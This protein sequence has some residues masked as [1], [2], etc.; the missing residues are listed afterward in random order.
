MRKILVVDDE[1]SIREMLTIYLQREGYAVT[2]ASD[3]AIALACCE[4][5]FYDIVIADIKM[6]K[7]DGIELLHKVRTLSPDTIFI[8]ITAFGSYETAKESMQEDAYDYITKPFDVEDIKKK[9]EAALAKRQQHTQP[10]GIDVSAQTAADAGCFAMIGKSM[11]MQ[12]IF[13]L[14][15]RAASAK[16][17]V[18]ITGESGTGKELVA[19]AI[20]R[21]SAQAAHP[22]IIINCG[23][24]PETLLESELFGYRKGAFTGAVKDKKGLLE[25]AHAGTLFLDEIGE[26]PLS[27][28]VKL[29]RMVQEKTFT[30]VG[31]TEEIKVDVRIISATNKDLAK[32]VMEGSFREDLYYRLNVINIA[33]PALRERKEDIPLLANFFLKK[34]AQETDKE[35]TE[36]SSFAMDCLMNYHFPGNIRE[37]ENIIE[38]GVALAKTSIMLPDSLDI[39]LHKTEE[40]QKGP[41]REITLP[42]EGMLLDAVLATYERAY[43]EEALRVSRGS[44]KEAARLLGVTYK[45]IR[46]RLEKYGID[47]QQFKEQ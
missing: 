10:P 25:A 5:D 41:S 2:C 16:S 20:H 23:G 38:R 15:Q 7:L 45:S 1:R 31:D 36:I 37:L 47:K 11:Q 6:P 12:K 9:I 43:I 39:S 46:L 28:Q 8:M 42:P 30:P 13:D 22:F 26:L 17:N 32:K 27:L 40:Q 3:G 18:L 29:L 35:V 33:M 34:Y 21:N 14:I 24:I 44:M 4:R 19:H